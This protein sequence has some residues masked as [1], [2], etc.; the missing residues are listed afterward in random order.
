MFAKSYDLHTLHMDTSV[1]LSYPE[2]KLIE[3]SKH[4]SRPP[5]CSFLGSKAV[6]ITGNFLERGKNP[7][8]VITDSG[9]DI[10][11]ISAEHLKKLRPS[12]R[13]KSGL[14]V[15]LT[16][17]TAKASNITGYV[18][19]PIY[20]ETSHG[21]VKLEVEAYVVSSMS[22]PFLLGNDFADQYNLSIIRNN[23]ETSVLFGD[24]GRSILAENSTAPILTNPAGEVYNVS[25]FTLEAS[26]INKYREHRTRSRKRKQERSKIQD[27][28][29][30]ADESLTIAPESCRRVRI[31]PIAFVEYPII[32]AE[33]LFNYTKNQESFFASPDSLIDK[34][35]PYLHISNF[36]GDPITICKGQPVAIR[37]RPD[38]YLDQKEKLS[39]EAKSSFEAHANMMKAYVKETLKPPSDV[40]PP[41]DDEPDIEGGPKTSE[42]EPDPTP[43][44]ALIEA[45]D[46]SKS[47]TLEQ[48]EALVKVLQ[49]NAAAFSLEGKPGN[50]PSKV[51]IRLKE[52]AAP[53]SL[54]PFPV[55]PAKR[56][57][58]DEQIDKWISQEII[59]PSESP[60]GAPAFIIL[61]HGKLR[62]VID[63]RKMNTQ[64]VP[65]EFPLPRQEEIFQ[66]LSGSQW[67]STFDAIYGFHQ[68]DLDP[69]SREITAFRTHRGLWQFLRMP[70]G[71]RNGPAAFQRVMQSVLAPFLW[72]F[73]LVYIDDIVVYSKTFEEHLQHLDLVLSTIAKSGITLSPPKSHIGY[74]SL[75]LL[76]QKVSRLG[77]STDSEKIAA[78]R[79]LEAPRNINELQMFLGMVVYFAAYIP[80][81][82]WIATPLFTLLKKNVLWTWGDLEQE[83]FD[84]AKEVLM[85]SP[86]R[87]Y[88]IP[89]LGY[90]LY[91]DA[92]DYGVAAVLQQIQPIKIRDL[93]GTKAYEKLKEA[94]DKGNPIPK[95][96]LPVAK[97][98]DDD[99]PP[100]GEWASDF[101]DT[102]VYVERVIAYWSR[103]LKSAE[104]N[105]SAT[106]REALGLKEALIKFQSYIEGEKTYAITDH[107]ALTW[108]K[109]FQNVNRRLLSWGTVF[110]AY[111]HLKIVHRA[112]RVHSNVDPISRLRRRVPYHEDPPRDRTE[113]VSLDQSDSDPMGDM[114]EKL[115]KKFESRVLTIASGYLKRSQKVS[116]AIHLAVQP[117][118]KSDPS[119]PTIAYTASTQ[120]SLVSYLAPA[121][122]SKWTKA[123]HNDNHFSKVFR[124]LREETNLSNPRYPQYYLSADGLLYFEDSIGS[125][126][127]CVPHDLREEIILHDHESVT[128][129]AH[130]GYHRTYNRLTC[131]YFW[132]RM[133]RDVK[134]IVLS[135]DECQRSKIRKHAPYGLLK[136]IPIPQRPFEVI[137]MDFIPELP[138]TRDG[139][140]NILVVV[141]KLTKFAIF[142][143]TS[144]TV[145][146][147]GSA[148]LVFKHV[149]SRFGLPRQIIADRDSRWAHGFWKELCIQSNVKR[150][151][152]TS[153]HPQA[154][155]QTEIMNQI[156]ETALRCYVSRDRNDWDAYLDSFAMSYNNT[157]HTATGY[158]PAQLLLGYL[159]QTAS[160]LLRIDSETLPPG[161][162]D[163]LVGRDPKEILDQ[164]ADHFQ[165][166]RLA[167][168][169]HARDS[170]V[171]SQSQQ[172]FHYN[173]RRLDKEFEVGQKVLI[174]THSLKLLGDE[175]GRGQKFHKLLDGPFEIQD[176][177][178]PITYR[179]RLSSN[180]RIHPV[181]NI[182]HLEPYTTP[183]RS[184]SDLEVEREPRRDEKHEAALQVEI[185]K[186]IGHRF[187]KDK[188]RR[189]KQYRIRYKDL[190]PEEDEWVDEGNMQAPDDVYEYESK[191]RKSKR[192]N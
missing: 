20:F 188:H 127:L 185:E 148:W 174:N 64:V 155:G 158:A 75:S 119:V 61:K 37:R 173:K 14:N 134:R 115:A 131:T 62:M 159:P 101:E 46:I 44:G 27:E 35:H 3:L 133:L 118:T 144:I 106:E 68:L 172:Q 113:S 53:I 135:C 8:K 38:E 136:S 98:V 79:D 102:T 86:V 97:G 129:G 141:D 26:R 137:T 89:G 139:L 22:T 121:E 189:I 91:S 109:V 73:A 58:I 28:Y 151:L 63:Y 107:A 175:P 48:R 143:P 31:N 140:D 116:E 33:R 36:S 94:Y 56:L 164:R 80:F 165:Q 19:L 15:K 10:T 130:S 108:S 55:S 39:P 111:P 57:V 156:L 23:G 177:Y 45:L 149:V 4:M 17:V 78:I 81:F 13:I 103:T 114:Y 90:R 2:G 146:D 100:V 7:V 25:S 9:S 74:Q 181:I 32:Y 163:Q 105:Y 65:D 145:N 112:G 5:G 59:E 138:I 51:K 70:L 132:P 11:L 166:T 24:S 34:L 104:R 178:S 179:L 93:R 96:V 66:A 154:D 47:L 52:D 54:A 6:S 160:N 40:P 1:T 49:K 41:N 167:H 123:Y 117:P 161:S 142:I 187:R 69:S 72:I 110:S 42:T 18:T 186:I 21:P 190:G 87:A 88:A 152:T 168:L 182:A 77:M 12:P 184:K 183:D 84:L 95:L 192:L 83:S 157:P 50:R 120:S 150:A 147:H 30:R 85:N 128:E 82:A 71:Y 162:E 171:F 153:H 124:V 60:W 122:K 76:G 43:A 67:L 191:L 29:I 176:K 99:V 169:Q 170:L 125:L 180:Y 16:Q 92:C 126:R